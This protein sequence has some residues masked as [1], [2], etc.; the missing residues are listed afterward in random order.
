[1]PK[2]TNMYRNKTQIYTTEFPEDFCRNPTDEHLC[3]ALP[4][5]ELR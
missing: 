2:V 4:K 5:C 3:V 1:M